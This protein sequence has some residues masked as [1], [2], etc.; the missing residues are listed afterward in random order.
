MKRLII[1][2]L[3][4]PFLSI[5]QPYVK[6]VEI[7]NK[8]ADKLYYKAKEWIA[9]NFRSANNVIQLDD[10][11][12]LKIIAKGSMQVYYVMKK[13]K[14]SHYV[15]FTL[16]TDFKDNKYRY[17]VNPT[18]IMIASAWGT[19]YNYSELKQCST[20]EGFREYYKKMKRPIWIFGPLNIKKAAE[21]NLMFLGEIDVKLQNLVDE[22]TEALKKDNDDNW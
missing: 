9:L 4:I 7:P 3:L 1:F 10:S 8:A 14:I 13:T 2:L 18:E 16:M 12:N 6:V 5:A 17:Y 19:S 22:L 21:R 11:K 20:P 15:L